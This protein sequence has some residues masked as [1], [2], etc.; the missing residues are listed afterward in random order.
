MVGG[1]C[2]TDASS[3]GGSAADVPPSFP[4]SSSFDAWA[5]VVCHVA[6]AAASA[7]T[8]A[9]AAALTRFARA[10]FAPP[11][12]LALR[13]P[14]A[15]IDRFLRRMR[16]FALDDDEDEEKNQEDT[17]QE[18][19]D[20]TT[21]AVVSPICGLAVRCAPK[22]HRRHEQE[23]SSTSSSSRKRQKSNG[24]AD[25]AKMVAAVAVGT[26]TDRRARRARRCADAG[27][28]ASAAVPAPGE[29]KRTAAPV[30]DDDGHSGNSSRGTRDGRA[31]RGGGGTG[32]GRVGGGRQGGGSGGAGNDG[33]AAPAGGSGGAPVPPRPCS[34][35]R[36]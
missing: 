31:G 5:A 6:E 28:G 32:C 1:R 17:K 26:R 30:V 20:A 36:R 18:G 3:G 8:P 12:S 11:S 4:A 13:P 14:C 7:T 19:S 33:G 24:S 10:V 27:L 21:A 9:H 16:R 34:A 35:G 22:Q 2:L 23:D 15:P 29:S 25:A